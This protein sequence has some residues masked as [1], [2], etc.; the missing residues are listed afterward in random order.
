MVADLSGNGV[1]PSIGVLTPSYLFKNRTTNGDSSPMPWSTY[2]QGNV[3]VDGNLGGGTV[4]IVAQVDGVDNSSK[5]VDNSDQLSITAEGSYPFY[6]GNCN[7]V[8]RL[9]GATSPNVSVMVLN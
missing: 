1:I 2:K 5:E 3:V 8:A 6:F 4:L 7:L 9:S